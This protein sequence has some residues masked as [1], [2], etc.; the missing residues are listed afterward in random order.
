[1]ILLILFLLKDCLE[2]HILMVRR[3]AIHL[4]DKTINGG[5][6]RGRG[7]GRGGERGR[8]RGGSGHMQKDPVDIKEELGSSNSEKIRDKIRAVESRDLLH[9]PTPVSEPQFVRK[10]TSRD[11]ESSGQESSDTIDDQPR[12]AKR[13]KIMD[14]SNTEM[15]TS[16][17]PNSELFKMM[18]FENFNTTKN[19][20][21]KGTDC[22]AVHFKQKTEYRQYMN[23]ELGFN[24]ELSPTRGDK[25]KIK[26]SLKKTRNNLN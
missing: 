20:H 14:S 24:R 11:V 23:R 5:R 25:K 10:E 1:M 21:V 13:R 7:R 16:E 4:K 2:A 26:M 15:L 19:K 17:P 9:L 12:L 6:G 18:G 8:D 3:I 22:Y